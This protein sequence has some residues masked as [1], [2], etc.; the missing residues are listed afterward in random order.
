MNKAFAELSDDYLGLDNDI[1]MLGGD[2][3]SAF[4]GNIFLLFLQSHPLETLKINLL[5]KFFTL[6]VCQLSWDANATEKQLL[7]WLPIPPDNPYGFCI[8]VTGSPRGKQKSHRPEGPT[9]AQDLLRG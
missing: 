1:W 8:G 3:V 4:L 9:E 5:L 2:T 7:F 6:L